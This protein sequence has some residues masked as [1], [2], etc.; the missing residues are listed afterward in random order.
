MTTIKGTL[1][2]DVRGELIEEVARRGWKYNADIEFPTLATLP[3]FKGHTP[4]SLCQLYGNMLIQVVNK[5]KRTSG[6]ELAIREVTVAQV[7]EWWN[8]TTKTGKPI[9]KTGKTPEKRKSE[10]ELI[11]AYNVVVIDLGLKPEKL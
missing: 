2:H 7:A 3:A 1:Q 8:G 6:V 4:L 10:D 9:K 5:Q 11:S